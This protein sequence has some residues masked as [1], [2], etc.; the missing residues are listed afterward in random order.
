MPAH[1]ADSPEILL[2]RIEARLADLGGKSRYWLDQQVTGG[3]ST[4]VVT[5]IERKRTIPKEPR[6]SR[7]AE[8]LG[9]TV[10]YL[11]GRTDDPSQLRSEVSVLDRRSTYFAPEPGMP[12]L[13][14]VGTGD[15]ADL[16]VCSE[17]GEMV[18]IE[19]AT[20]DPEYHVTYIARPKALQG[21]RDAYAIYFHGDSMVPRFEPGEVGIAQPSRPAGPGDYVVVQLRATESD[22]VASVIVK[23]LVR[24]N[25]RE[26]VLEQFNPPLVFKVPRARV[27]RVHR[28]M[29]PTAALYG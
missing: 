26:L 25:A 6:L 8:V 22:E 19:R 21:D 11:M 24:Q 27:A 29:P 7:M 1:R 13:P 4:K 20:F 2:E 17:S 10:D 5:E 28:L 14:I 18:S 23:R 15:C 12:M 16:E 9:T 3:K